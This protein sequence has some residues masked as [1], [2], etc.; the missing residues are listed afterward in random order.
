MNENSEPN[1]APPVPPAPSAAPQPAFPAPADVAPP[2][3]PAPQEPFPPAV[4]PEYAAPAYGAPTAPPYAAQEYPTAP[5]AYPAAPQE[6]TPPQAYAAAP[7]AYPTAPQEYAAATQVYPPAAPG[8][9]SAPAYPAATGY[10]AA[11][12]YPAATSPAYPATTPEQSRTLGILALVLGFLAAV[13][14]TL[15]S[16]ITGWAAAAGAMRHA[17][18]LSPD[19]LEELTE[20]Q[21]LALLSPVRDLV[22]W[23]EIGFWA[24]TAMGIAA[25]VLGIVAIVT[26][27]GRGFGIAALI[28]AVVGSIVY[29]VVVFFAVVG[30]IAAGT[31]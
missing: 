12:G 28:V 1:A 27:R 6:Y 13:G 29:G 26:R 8:Y 31:V 5:Q 18:G 20:S 19:S 25:I 21:L 24:G 15:L 10:P 2:A 9:S 23:S 17:V 7:Q 14:A 16:A 3:Q 11:P 30:G 4:A 22:L